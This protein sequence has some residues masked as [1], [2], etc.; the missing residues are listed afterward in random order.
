[1]KLIPKSPNYLFI[2]ALSVTPVWA[3]SADSWSRFDAAAVPPTA[4]T[5]P[6]YAQNA[7]PPAA[8]GQ[9]MP[10]AQPM[11]TAPQA[12]PGY[13][14]PPPG[15]Q[16]P[17]YNGQQMPNQQYGSPQGPQGSY[18][19]RPS[20]PLP[21]T[22]NLPSGKYLTVRM[23]S[24]LTT[25][26][27]QPGDAFTA[28]LVEPLVIDGFVVAHRGQIVN[29]RVV[30][31]KKAGRVSG[32]SSMRVELTELLLA[33]GQQLPIHT[34]LVYREGRTSVGR[35]AGAIAG[36]TALGAI[37]GAAAVGTGFGAGMGALGGAVVGTIGVL[38]TRGRP[39]VLHPESVLTF[40]VE[41]P[42]AIST[43]NSGGAFEPVS[44][45]DYNAQG[46]RPRGPGYG[47]GQGYSG[48][49]APY[50]YG[51]YP[52]PYAYGYGFGPSV[53]IGFYGRGFYGRGWGG[54]WR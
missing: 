22:L 20:A 49:A 25:D 16:Q 48:G 43:T 46:F 40:R 23:N 18:D 9:Q 52:Y 12:Q 38:V 26:R 45:Q 47:Y 28:S 2:A 35:D 53:G 50:P 14:A 33:D 41:Q 10:D 39:T 7:P 42:L 31:V 44:R 34:Q 27:N 3:Q 21:V 11:Q 17:Y 54:R 5:D 4:Q 19:Q 13:G 24:F 8:D 29:G 1:M 51:A 36:T 30:D 37:V 32:T 6:A 15:Q